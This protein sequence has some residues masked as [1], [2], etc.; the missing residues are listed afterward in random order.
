MLNNNLTLKELT[1]KKSITLMMVLAIITLAAGQVPPSGL[2]TWYPPLND[3]AANTNIVKDLSSGGNN[4]VI[5]PPSINVISKTLNSFPSLPNYPYVLSLNQQSSN[6]SYIIDSLFK[7]PKSSTD[8][9]SISLWYLRSFSV[10]TSEQCV[11]G[12]EKTNRIQILEKDSVNGYSNLYAS[13][14][15]TPCTKISSKN[16][17]GLW[18]HVVLVRGTPI[19]RFYIDNKLVDSLD[20]TKIQGIAGG[21]FLVGAN[22]ISSPTKF[23]SGYIGNLR[24]YNK[25]LSFQEVSSL[26]SECHATSII[27]KNQGASTPAGKANYKNSL[28]DLQG[29]NIQM[30]V[31]RLRG[32]YLKMKG[33][34]QKIIVR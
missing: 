24:I 27:I 13:Y 5:N 7:N 22:N 3:T 8:S 2:I 9:I 30:N 25:A 16:I 21:S 11:I 34:P 12:M 29:R 20:D 26:Y 19:T 28:Y 1:M 31:N 17:N 18:H 4:G 32:I 10:T 6:H 23:Y 33:T 14:N 15:G